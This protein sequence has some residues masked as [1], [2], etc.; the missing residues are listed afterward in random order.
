[1]ILQTILMLVALTSTS[2]TGGLETM[3]DSND[4]MGI[5]MD[6]L[7][8]IG[9][10]IL[11][12]LKNNVMI[13][14]DYISKQKEYFPFGS[15]FFIFCWGL[16][17]TLRRLLS[18]VAFFTPS[19]GLFSILHH[20]QAEQVPYSIRNIYAYKIK[21]DDKITVYNMSETVYW[22][23]LDRWNYNDMQKPEPP[24]YTEYTGL[25]L[26]ESSFAFLY[27]MIYQYAGLILVK[28]FISEDF[29]RRENFFEKFIHVLLNMNLAFPYTDW[30]VGHYS[31]EH[32]KQR[33]RKVTKEMIWCMI[34]NINVSLMMTLPLFYTFIK[35]KERHNFLIALIGTK[36]EEDTSMKNIELLI[37]SVTLCLILFSIFEVSFYFFYHTKVILEVMAN[38]PFF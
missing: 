15:S 34:I 23:H 22:R 11:I 6:P 5:N 30:D 24:C 2:T 7:I 27:L 3:F 10:S 20:W 36:I 33:Y 14:V 32:F 13:H 19:L 38:S 1:M 8:V 18:S 17:A 26:Q 25:S 35:I 12:S 4:F 28:L 9:L 37:Y 29:M 21:Y 16:F 31:I